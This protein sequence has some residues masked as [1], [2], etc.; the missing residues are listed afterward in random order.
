MQTARRNHFV[1]SGIRSHALVRRCRRGRPDGRAHLVG[2]IKR[3]LRHRHGDDRTAKAIHLHS[4]S[5]PG[6]AITRGLVKKDKRTVRIDMVAA[7]PA[8]DN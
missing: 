5:F 7:R 1:I 2:D 3:Y 8:I 6:L 4:R